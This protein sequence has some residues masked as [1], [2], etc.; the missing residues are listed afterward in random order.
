MTG[1]TRR[2]GLLFGALLV[3]TGSSQ[4]ARAQ[5]YAV[6][7]ENPLV[8]KISVRFSAIP[9]EEAL[10]RLRTAHG[11]PLAYSR[12]VIP[13]GIHVSLVATGETVER[14]L[15]S[16]LRGSGLKV[17]LTAN[18]TA[19]IAPREQVRIAGAP[20]DPTPL[21]TGVKEL[22]QIV[23]MGTPATGAPQWE[24]PT[25]VSVVDPAKL[26][27]QR[28]SRTTELMRSALPGVVLWDRGPSGPPSEIAG[29][30]GASSF[31]SRGLKTYVDGVEVASPSLFTLIDPRSIE[32]IEVIRGPQGAALYG[33]DAIDGVIQI[34]T[35]KGQMGPDVKPK[36]WA[37]VAAGPFDRQAIPTMLRQDH[38]G[39]FSIG[40]PS[41]SM[42]IEGAMGSVGSSQSIPKTREWSLHSGGQAILGKVLV[43]ATA[44]LSKFQYTE[45]V[46]GA[47][48]VRHEPLSS[49]PSD[50]SSATVGVTATHQITDRWS[51]TLVAGFDRAAGELPSS[52]PI[53]AVM[54]QPLGATHEVANKLSL[55]YSSTLDLSVASDGLATLTGGFEQSRLARDRSVL[56][57]ALGG[58]LVPLYRDVTEN[59]GAFT[60]A[61]LRFGSLVLSAGTRAER[62][63]SF[64][65]DYGTAWASTVGASWAR[66]IGTS[67]L[68]L[69]AA[70]GRGIR[71]P[72]PGMSRA[73]AT[74]S[75]RQEANPSLAPER[76][77][78]IE[79]GAEFYS[80]PGIYGKLTWYDQLASGLIQSTLTSWVPG[81]QQVYQYQNVGA[82]RN[83][84]VEL[85]FG[86]RSG[87]LTGDFQLY[88]TRSVVQQLAP[89]YYGSLRVGDLLPEV[90]SSAGSARLSYEGNRFR[91]TLGSSYLGTWRAYDFGTLTAADAANL[92]EAKAWVRSSIVNYAG[93]FKPFA[94]F[95]LDLNRQLTPFISIDNL[96]NSSRA[97]QNNGYPPAGRSVLIGVEVRP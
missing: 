65:S 48:A 1:F 52:T 55:R 86:G 36:A 30:R 71:P 69:R 97:E 28:I 32:R 87:R 50:L 43:R 84:G 82:I 64:G 19:V 44:G 83:R 45:D 9:L 18:G 39:G 26:S 16:L 29:V 17:V 76:Q 31:T 4:Y 21:A 15:E 58:G 81:S 46:L 57:L 33:S 62:N 10:S 14:V 96:T 6:A 59:T 7:S 88:F 68:R 35:R 79:L 61:R 74:A 27:N 23:V 51:Q 78:G 42:A 41:A 91:F 75:V 53:F 60:Q 34:I 49:D 77:G 8:R 12:E 13:A 67:T 37:T 20:D 80:G 3:A 54:R 24:Q 63:S 11:V 5:S 92:Q 72:E 90:P 66:P 25:A 38:A 40:G 73:M 22:D 85:E 47:L 94:S 89:H 95:S 70:W 2:L 93:M 56:D